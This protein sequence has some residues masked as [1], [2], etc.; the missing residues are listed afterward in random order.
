MGHQLIFWF[1]RRCDLIR[2]KCLKVYQPQQLRYYFASSLAFSAFEI[3]L[4]MAGKSD[5]IVVYRSLES[6]L[7]VFK[8][9]KVTNDID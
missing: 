7:Q 8:D 1:M 2:H 4:N 6:V 3:A 5:N 9:E